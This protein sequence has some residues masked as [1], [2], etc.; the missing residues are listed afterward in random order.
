M[1]VKP[2]L[3]KRKK[4]FDCF[5]TF[6][7]S[8]EYLESIEINKILLTPKLTY[9]YPN[10]GNEYNYYK[11][12]CYKDGVN[13]TRME[14]S[15]ENEYAINILENNFYSKPISTFAFMKPSLDKTPDK[16][17]YGIKFYDI[18]IFKIKK[19]I[20]QNVIN[21][22]K[23]EKC[24][25]FVSK[26]PNFQVLEMICIKFLHFK[27]LN[28]LN[29]LTQF[30]CFFE[31][32]K[33]D[34]FH[35]FNDEN[36]NKE[37]NQ[38]LQILYRTTSQTSINYLVTNYPNTLDLKE[39]FIC[40]LL[41][42]VLPYYTSDIFFQILIMV[43][44]E[45]KVIFY[46][47]N[48]ELISFSSILFS[49]IIK[50]FIWKFPLIPNLPLDQMIMLSS[51]IPYIAGIL[52]DEKD[53]IEIKSSNTTNL[54]KVGNKQI[55]IEYSLNKKYN[56]NDCLYYLN[57]VIDRSFWK[58]E[59]EDFYRNET[60]TK[61]ICNEISNDIYNGIITSIINKMKIIIE[62]GKSFVIENVKKDIKQKI[63]SQW[64][65]EF[66]NEFCETEM[67]ICFYDK[68]AVNNK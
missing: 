6:G 16:Y 3:L 37:I 58:V 42:K 21:V 26:E 10:I 31:K 51:P 18:F 8:P 60:I 55:T 20:K 62:N 64:D 65:Y 32:D 40:W 44:L 34:N 56:F 24:F 36:N 27:K 45:Q 5:I 67:F 28:Y 19:N 23:Y 4:L 48:L 22:F 41:K 7:I 14:I 17:V 38:L 15:S 46:G 13:V 29:N 54:I 1:E 47:D 33:F 52:A 63:I 53:L 25:L 43:L 11:N 12:F 57:G 35:L 50:P 39:S 66:F 30:T 2:N 9:C 59:S 49:N 68:M 61:K